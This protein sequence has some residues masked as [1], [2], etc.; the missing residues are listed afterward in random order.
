MVALSTSKSQIEIGSIYNGDLVILEEETASDNLRR[1]CLDCFKENFGLA[2]DLS[3]PLD[4][5]KDDFI[6][7]ATR[8]KKHFTNHDTTKQ[9]L[10]DLIF[11][12]YSLYRDFDLYYDVPRV[13]LI[14]NSGFIST[15]ISYNYRPHRDTWYGASQG[16]INHWIA[17]ENV[18]KDSTFFIAPSF[19]KETIPNSSQIF[20]LD[21]WD[22]HHRP[23]ASSNTSVEERPHPLPEIEIPES[24]KY[25]IAIGKGQEICFSGHHLHG[26]L[27]NFTPKLRISIDFRVE[28]VSSAY[29]PPKNIDNLST[30]CY[31]KYMIKHLRF[32]S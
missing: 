14:P 1:F 28:V 15:G 7:N 21:V 17:V 23:A 32:G 6:A 16:Q 2:F 20:D 5:S 10:E 11:L 3:A 30:G 22:R 4:I 31:R 13:R 8:M 18:T 29:M 27:P 19:F 12:R 24:R 9:L 25:A 26:S